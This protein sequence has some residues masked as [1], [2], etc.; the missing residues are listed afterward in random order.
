MLGP[1]PAGVQ[2]PQAAVPIEDLVAS[3]FVRR[4]GTAVLQGLLP[5]EAFAA[6]RDEAARLEPQAAR[7]VWEGSEQEEWRGGD[8][9]R[10]YSLASGGPVQYAVFASPGMA[11]ALS[12]IVGFPLALSGAGTY[13]YYHEPGDFLALHR[14][15]LHCDVAVLT[16]VADTASGVDGRGALRVYPA[17]ALEPLSAVRS[18]PAPMSLDLALE[19]GQTAVLLGGIIPHEVR[20]MTAGQRRTMS[21]MCFRALSA[22][23]F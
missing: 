7:T 3:D 4:G 12:Q 23:R 22:G 9:A 15:V 1:S 16:C 20:P 6:L 2:P 8:P 5:A 11:P 21:V 17:Y 18:H 10:A 14:D 19:P 13:S